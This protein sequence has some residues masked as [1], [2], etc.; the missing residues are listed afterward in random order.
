MEMRVIC[1]AVMA[2]YEI[3]QSNS[4]VVGY[5]SQKKSVEAAHNE[6]SLGILVD[7]TKAVLAV[8]DGVGGAPKGHEA[9]RTAIEKLIRNVR[10]HFANTRKQKTIRIQMLDGI[11]AAHSAI[12]SKSTG[13]RTTLTACAIDNSHIRAYQVGDSSMI[14]CGQKGAL[15]Y[16]ATEHSPVGF[17][18]RSGHLNEAAALNHQDRNL[19]SNLVGEHDMFIEIGPPIDFASHDTVLIASDGIFDNFTTDELI[20]FIRKD[21]MEE[22]M[23]KLTAA[24]QNGTNPSTPLRKIDD[25]SFIV[26]RHL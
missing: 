3:L 13:E 20:D 21:S 26:C 4:F 22:V 1:D 19:V 15:K 24:C 23:T 9:S 8:A 5:Y 11:E 6:D 25:I 17:M 12:N 18:L 7:N 2:N 14:V 10:R 16:K